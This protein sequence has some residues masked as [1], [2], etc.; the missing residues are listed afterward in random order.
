MPR[1]TLRAD[2]KPIT[3]FYQIMYLDW[4]EHN[5]LIPSRDLPLS[6]K[7]I[8]ITAP[9]HY[10]ARLCQQLICQGGLP[11]LMPAIEISMLSDFT[12]LDRA[13]KRLR[14]FDWIA[15]ISSYCIQAFFDRLA[16]LNLPIAVLS[17]SRLCAIGQDMEL[18]NNYSCRMDLIPQ[19]PT[20]EELLRSLSQIPDIARQT[21]LLPIPEVMGF[22]EPN[23]VPDMV[24]GLQQLGM[25]VSVVPTYI[26]RYLH[27]SLYPVELHLLQSGNIDAIAFFSTAEVASFLQMLDD[28]RDYPNCPIA[29]FGPDTAAH[30][31]NLGLDVSIISQ[32]YSS[33]AGFAEA[34]GGFFTSQK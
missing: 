12:Q 30:A 14:E 18:L 28:P 10:G 19:E 25:Q 16:S 31:K 7:R 27:K 11:F 2:Y 9:R 17:N 26:T 1:S 33:F 29:C 8:L 32:D 15:F 24:A 4:T 22:P 20:P 34:I 6:G 3:G 23:V 13:L 5:L 21:V